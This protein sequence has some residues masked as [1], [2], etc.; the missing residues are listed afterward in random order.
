MAAQSSVARTMSRGRSVEFATRPYRSADAL[1][2]LD[3][4]VAGLQTLKTYA[5][6]D[7]RGIDVDLSHL[8]DWATVGMPRYLNSDR[9]ARYNALF[10]ALGPACHQALEQIHQP[11]GMHYV[12]DRTLRNSISEFVA[13]ASSGT[14]ARLLRVAL[15]AEL[16]AE[17]APGCD[18]GRNPLGGVLDLLA[19]GAALADKS[20]EAPELAL[21]GGSRIRLG[22]SHGFMARDVVGRLRPVAERESEQFEPADLTG[23]HVS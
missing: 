10:V 20:P 17:P 19:M 2:A 21:Q 1:R 4:I 16:S 3:S 7:D 14:N 6:A 5:Q 23:R 18:P 9:R 22:W 12:F 11:D 15:A 13:K 8:V